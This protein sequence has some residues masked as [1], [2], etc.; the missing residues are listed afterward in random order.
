MI[1]NPY[2]ELS[3][4]HTPALF[5]N[6]VSCL[7]SILRHH[8]CALNAKGVSKCGQQLFA[9]LLHGEAI[10]ECTAISSVKINIHVD[11][12][13]INGKFYSMGFNI[14]NNF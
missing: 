11:G 7:L 14:Q 8:R 3:Y 4:A 13:E 2:E 9:C 12:E 10:P 6:L 1:K 5:Q